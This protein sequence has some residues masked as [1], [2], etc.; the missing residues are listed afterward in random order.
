MIRNCGHVPAGQGRQVPGVVGTPWCARGMSSRAGTP[1][2]VGVRGDGRCT[3]TMGTAPDAFMGMC[4]FV[5]LLCARPADQL[6]KLARMCTWVCVYRVASHSLMLS[7]SLRLSL[8]L[9]LTSSHHITNCL[10]HTPSRALMHTAANSQN[11]ASPPVVRDTA[12]WEALCAPCTQR[13]TLARTNHVRGAA[14]QVVGAHGSKG[15]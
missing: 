1:L 11:P 7:L 14:G 2:I 10:I 5:C 12:R 6:T 15:M 3:K 9:T 13:H 8:S 4:R